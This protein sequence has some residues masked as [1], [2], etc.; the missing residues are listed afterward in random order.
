MREQHTSK[1][2]FSAS[3][4]NGTVKQNKEKKKIGF[5]AISAVQG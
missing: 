2:D 4:S 1:I 3:E 5:V